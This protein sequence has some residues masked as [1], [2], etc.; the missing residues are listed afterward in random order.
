MSIHEVCEDPETG[1]ITR[2]GL[3]MLVWDD[4]DPVWRRDGNRAE[5]QE[6]GEECARRAES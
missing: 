3:E 1:E 6:R 4:F 5:L 2:N